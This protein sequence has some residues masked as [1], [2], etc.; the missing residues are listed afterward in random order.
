MFWQRNID[1]AEQTKVLNVLGKWHRDTEAIDDATDAMRLASA[2]ESNG[3]QSDRFEEERLATVR[4]AGKLL[5]ENK[6]QRNWPELVDG[7]GSALISMLQMSF[8][9]TLAQQLD[10]LR[11]QHEYVD[12]LKRNSLTRA[13]NDALAS[14]HNQMTRSLNDMAKVVATIAKHYRVTPQEYAR[15]TL[16][17]I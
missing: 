15:A 2:S 6:D 12:G 7:K 14:L 11:L 5:E 3:M 17:P 8:N 1:P 10:S 9:E 16:S 13:D 4:L